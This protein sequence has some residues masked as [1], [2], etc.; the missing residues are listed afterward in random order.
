M[1]IIFLPL[2]VFAGA[3]EDFDFAKKMYDDTLYEEAIGKFQDIVQQYPSS[4]YAEHAQFYLGNSY[5]ELEQFV[6]AIFAYK[7][8]LENYPN[9][10]IY[11]QTV[12]RL[13]EALFDNKNYF[14]AAQYYQDIIYNYPQSPYALQSLNKI[15]QALEEAGMYNEAIL[16]SM[17]IIESYADNDQMPAIMLSLAD[18]Y[19]LN[20]M[21]ADYE[22]TLLS[23]I[24][25]YPESDEKWEA[26]HDLSKYYYDKNDT[27]DALQLLKNS[28]VET[29]PR[30]Y[31]QTL[32]LLYAELLDRSG[33]TEES[34]KQY[35]EFYRKFDTYPKRD[36]IGLKIATLQY[37]L[38]EYSD[39][40]N[41]C[42]EFL[43]EFPKSSYT[44]RIKYLQSAGLFNKND[45][46]QALHM[47]Q[48]IDE[49]D[50]D[51][52]ILKDIEALRAEIY[53]KQKDF[54]KAISSYLTIIKKFP[55]IVS[56]DSVYFSIGSIY[57][58]Y[59]L[60]YENAINYYS[61]I[62]TTYPESELRSD[63]LIDVAE[64][65]EEL[66]NYEKALEFYTQA[67]SSRYT[68]AEQL[69]TLGSKIEYLRE[70]SIKNQDQALENLLQ[71]FA[72]FVQSND[73]IETIYSL[74]QIYANNL[75][76]FDGALELL[77]SDPLFESNPKLLLLKGK[78]FL[79][80]AKKATM[81]DK[82]DVDTY[83]KQAEQIFETIVKDFTD[84]PEKAYAEFYLIK[85]K[86]QTFEQ[87]SEEYVTTLQQLSLDFIDSYG[88]FPYIGQ[89]YFDLGAALMEYGGAR[90]QI[91][92]YLQQAS[93]LTQNEHIRNKANEFLGNLYLENEG[94]I[95]ARNQYQKID[96]KTIYSDPSL[97]YNVGFVYYKLNSLSQ[98]IP[99]FEYYVQ[100][101]PKQEHYSK[102]L[103][104]LG[105]MYMILDQS[106]KA[107]QYYALL[108]E[109]EP[110]DDL[111]RKLRDLYILEN[112]FD[113]AINISLEIKEL[114][115][116]DRRT[117]AQIYEEQGNLAYSIV[118][119]E[120]IISNNITE[121]DMLKDTEQLARLHFLVDD[122]AKALNNYIK[123][124][125]IT[126][127]YKHPFE[128][129]NYLNWKQIAENTVVAYYRQKNRTQ[130]ENFEKYYKSIIQD[131][132]SIQAHITLE[133]GIYYADLD[134]RKARRLFEEV[135]DDYP[136]TDYADDA[137]LEFAILEL[138]EK[139]FKE[140]T[141]YLKILVENYS[142][143]PLVNNAYLKLGS[144]HFSQ[145]NYQQALE[146]YQ[147]VIQRDTGGTYAMRAIENF[148]L[149]CKAMGEW[150]LA[151]EAYQM[152]IERFGS[153]ELTPETIF[154]IS[155]C[156]YMDKEYKKAIQLFKTIQDKFT[157]S[158]VKAE[159]IYWIGE[160]YYGLKEYDHAI[161][162]LL[163]IVY[164][165]S[166]LDQWYVN[167]NIKIAM[168]YEKQ[169][170][171]DKAR[172]F[173]QNIIER[174]GTN[175]NW[176]AEAK[177]L[178]DALP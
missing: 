115:N 103:E 97:L 23:L 109:N 144:V 42:K 112:R 18:V 147:K 34:L 154:E 81:D 4:S 70:F 10:T 95:A 130:A 98:S 69:N 59:V 94:Y 61:I 149:T 173:Y 65:Y 24:S 155:Y 54:T 100:N 71:T 46:T 106:D 11:P 122:M 51:V 165:Y 48:M 136:Q 55:H 22:S 39:M 101:Y 139:N 159:I 83:Y 164:D 67:L 20:N 133:R 168:A 5:V 44:A 74:V 91:I 143:S 171:F 13:A 2:F 52:S 177:K 148:A 99:Y 126:E 30:M 102:V 21:P 15:I 110:D 78:I 6:N 40:I 9:T 27:S 131:D 7:R 166:F 62:L 38:G 43:E 75:K 73:Y 96:K 107:I 172:L 157:D 123:I 63:A 92:M 35:E 57:K 49:E 29:I 142:D 16:V 169:Q 158:E 93:N 84:I 104:Y 1:F 145:G 66:N 161:E 33:E 31:E 41:I 117:L 163:K 77:K 138:S 135:I 19:K 108:A 56:V 14:E 140:A 160:S 152:L 82:E 150:M 28:L 137:Y 32:L 134:K 37:E 176:G 105:S 8:L 12:Y 119:Y 116:S 60:N 175:S 146:Y 79:T 76:D 132:D 162:T 17:D 85:L 124:Y 68:D 120:R 129:Y 90:E 3:K 118:Q 151:I 170:K 53:L 26:I 127:S 58:N 88:T 64:S 50:T 87:G 125:N 47:L 80:L 89:V 25:E 128:T 174:Y 167:A 121:S 156:Y 141:E 45:Y 72:K 114:N 86:T 153:P 111:L 113:E 36:Q 178:L